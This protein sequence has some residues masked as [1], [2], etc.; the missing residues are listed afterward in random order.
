M[1]VVK[2]VRWRID[3]YSR[4][5]CGLNLRTEGNAARVL[6]SLLIGSGA[7]EGVCSLIMA[8][9]MMGGASKATWELEK[10]LRGLW[11]DLV[12]ELFECGNM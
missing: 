3:T 1:M 5:E 8:R 9:G 4:L 7:T 11:A 2:V 10:Q 6:R 12:A